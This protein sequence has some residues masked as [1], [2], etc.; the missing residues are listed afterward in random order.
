M[1]CYVMLCYVMLSN[2]RLFEREVLKCLH[3]LYLFIDFLIYN[4]LLPNKPQFI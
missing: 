3:F 4:F 1:L 2:F